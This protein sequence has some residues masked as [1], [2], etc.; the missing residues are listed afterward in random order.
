MVIYVMC[1]SALLC[2]L[3]ILLHL[4]G[5]WQGQLPGSEICSGSWWWRYGS[6]GITFLFLFY[7]LCTWW[8]QKTE[9]LLRFLFWGFYLF[10]LQQY[11]ENRLKY[12]DAQKAEGKNIYP[13]K[14]FVTLSIPE[15]IDKYGGLSNG[16]HLEDVSVSLAGNIEQTLLVYCFM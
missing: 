7:L 11:Y 3:T 16:E 15:Y 2:L 12:L 8:V 13:H 4:E 9:V 6:H 10:M 5:C 1:F 14:F